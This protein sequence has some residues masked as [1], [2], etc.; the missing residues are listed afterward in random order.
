MKLSHV[1]ATSHKGM[2]SLSFGKM[3]PG[4]WRTG[5]HLQSLTKYPTLVSGSNKEA[6]HM[7]MMVEAIN[8]LIL[9]RQASAFWVQDAF[10]IGFPGNCFQKAREEIFQE[11]ADINLAGMQRHLIFKLNG[12]SVYS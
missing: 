1:Y 6:S 12:Y 4:G 5:S 8:R 10:I 9:T 11:E 3:V 7:K 2:G